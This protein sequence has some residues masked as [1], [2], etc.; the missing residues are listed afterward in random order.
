[1][2]RFIVGLLATLGFLTLLTVV[3]S[4]VFLYTG[5]FAARPLPRS[6]ILSLDLRRADG[7]HASWGLDAEK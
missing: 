2:R 7:V 1:M 3:G 5:P 4:A 6:M